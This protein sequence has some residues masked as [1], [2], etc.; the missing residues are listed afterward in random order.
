MNLIKLLLPQ[1]KTFPNHSKK[2]VTLPRLCY[3]HIPKTAGTAITTAL[4]AIY[5]ADKIFPAV[6]MFEYRSH[7]PRTFADYL[8]FKG[9]IHYF[10]AISNLPPDTKYITI[11]RDP[12]ER[13]ISLYFFLRDVVPND[14]L[15]D[16]KLPYQQKAA[17][18][19][20]KESGICEYLRSSLVNVQAS[21][22]N[23]QLKVLLDKETFK[24]IGTNPEDVVDKALSSIENFFCY[25]IQEFTPFFVY[26]LSQKIG[27]PLDAP[28]V[29]NSN[30]KKTRKIAMLDKGELQEAIAIIKRF[31]QAEMM[32]YDNAKGQVVSRINTY[33]ASQVPSTKT[34]QRAKHL[35]R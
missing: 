16:P 2:R 30:P 11:L 1:Y 9:H 5:P 7:D 33:F 22:R 20:A 27:V 21:T 13:I 3:I 32:F 29:I 14:S 15:T 4:N 12:V 17:I 34:D 8:L 18:K 6:F 25:G 28:N 10:F 35:W 24:Q 19:V 23:Q 26:E 31:N